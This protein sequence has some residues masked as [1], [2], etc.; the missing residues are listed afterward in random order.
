MADD[1]AAR[2]RRRRAHRKGD[3]RLCVPGRCPDAPA[4]DRQD[5]PAV[6]EIERRLAEALEHLEL[7]DDD[8]RRVVAVMAVRLARS[9]D[10]RV[11][12]AVARELRGCVDVLWADELDDAEQRVAAQTRE[13]LAGLRAVTG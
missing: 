7:A 13:L 11:S 8:P 6:G 9:L 4:V 12:A 5:P 3:H 10:E 2:Q 1:A